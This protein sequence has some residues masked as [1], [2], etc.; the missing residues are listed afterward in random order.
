MIKVTVDDNPAIMCISMTCDK[1]GRCVERRVN[2]L[3]GRVFMFLGID[4]WVFV[5]YLRWLLFRHR[6][7]YILV[8]GGFNRLRDNSIL[9]RCK[10]GCDGL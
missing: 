2:L 10:G 4:A 9:I 5:R 7:F 1:C 6:F 8:P 3:Y